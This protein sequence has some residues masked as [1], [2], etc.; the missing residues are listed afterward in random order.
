MIS[1]ADLMS[2]ITGRGV[3]LVTGV[4]CSFLT[5]VINRAISDTGVRYLS[6][7]QEGEAVAIAAGSWLGGGLG[8]A[9]TQN[10]GLG[11]MVNPLTSLLY[12]ARVPALLLVTWRGQPGRPDEPQHELM[13]RTTTSLL[14]LLEVGWAMLPDDAAA[15]PD[16]LDASWR[17]MHA[18]RSPQALV[19]AKGCVADEPLAE[20]A[21][22][23]RQASVTRHGTTRQPPTRLA[24]LECLLEQLPEPA[25]VVATTGKTSRELYT[26]GDRPQNFYLVGAMGSASSVG[27]GVALHTRRPVVVVDG[28]GAA[29]MRLGS[30]ATIG[31]HG[32]DNLVHVVLDNGVHDSTG[33]QRTLSAGVDL[34]AVAAACGYASVHECADLRDFAAVLAAV[35]TGATAGTGPVFVH[36]RIRPGSDAALGRPT[37]T[38]QEVAARF[39]E[40]V[41]GD[42][43]MAVAGAHR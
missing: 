30:L 35:T 7:T 3:T 31:V 32:P 11:N 20:P 26:I 22:V 29:L 18:D 37:V 13:G 15:L 27:L 14:D 23:P 4:P 1:A 12:P 9:I 10:S 2:G 16:V 6:A 39:R 25:A 19:I 42:P 38:P 5:P 34:P 33:G 17:R 43:R 40:Y 24:A 21:P 28:D 41:T 36:L 8:C